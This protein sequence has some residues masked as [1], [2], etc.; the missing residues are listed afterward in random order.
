MERTAPAAK[1]IISPFAFTA[2]GGRNEWAR[3]PVKCSSIP[4]GREKVTLSARD[5]GT[6]KLP[7]VS[8]GASESHCGAGRFPDAPELRRIPPVAARAAFASLAA[9]T[10]MYLSLCPRCLEILA[11]P[12]YSQQR[13]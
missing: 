2:T 13:P 7:P 3:R 1:K 8:K 10:L 4:L 9:R 11:L 12:S 6:L 5:G